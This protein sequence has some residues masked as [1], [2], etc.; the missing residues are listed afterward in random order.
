MHFL[1]HSRIRKSLGCKKLFFD[2]KIIHIYV[3]ESRVIYHQSAIWHFK[4]RKSSVLPGHCQDVDG[5]MKIIQFYL[6][7][8]LEANSTRTLEN[9]VKSLFSAPA[10]D[11]NNLCHFDLFGRFSG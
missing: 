10:F 1:I 7:E 6:G 3:G 9:T 4:Q 5:I 2:H 8:G 11:G